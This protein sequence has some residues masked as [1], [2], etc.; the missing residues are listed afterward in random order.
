MKFCTEY[1]IPQF[2][3]KNTEIQIP[4]VGGNLRFF[5]FLTL[6]KGLSKHFHGL[7][8]HFEGLSKQFEN[9]MALKSNRA[10]R[11]QDFNTEYRKS[12]I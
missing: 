4:K 12:Q 10:G 3:N 1:K 11:W 7:C 8:K 6:L 5:G 9:P 2:L